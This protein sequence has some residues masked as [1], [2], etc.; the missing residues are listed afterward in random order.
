MSCLSEHGLRRHPQRGK[1]REEERQT[2]RSGP[3]FP[4]RNEGKNQ[5]NGIKRV[6]IR[7][8][9]PHTDCWEECS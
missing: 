2:E 7:K 8:T 1:G 6:E 3:R 5:A 4:Q 9:N